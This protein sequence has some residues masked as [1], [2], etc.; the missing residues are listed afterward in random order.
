MFLD[1][2]QAVRQLA[3]A[4]AVLICLRLLH[5]RGGIL[6]HFGH[7]YHL[8][9][10]DISQ[11]HA[12]R[13]SRPPPPGIPRWRQWSALRGGPMEYREYPDHLKKP[14]PTREPQ[15]DDLE[16]LLAGELLWDAATWDT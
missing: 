10:T 12:S 2:A 1:P 4:R 5:Q 16:D 8:G 3:E 15:P 11:K 9:A 14:A 6:V 13:G 7:G